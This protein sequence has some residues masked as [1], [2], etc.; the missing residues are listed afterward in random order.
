[1]SINMTPQQKA[2]IA[3]AGILILTLTKAESWAQALTAL[4]NPKMAQTVLKRFEAPD[5]PV[6]L[7]DLESWGPLLEHQRRAPVKVAVAVCAE[8]GN[9]VLYDQSSSK[10]MDKKTCFL[11]NGC[12]GKY[13][14]PTRYTIKPKVLADE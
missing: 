2:D 4:R 3:G 13:L 9:W 14:K 12:P 10:A 5:I 8:C 11:R 7:E 1:M 6:A